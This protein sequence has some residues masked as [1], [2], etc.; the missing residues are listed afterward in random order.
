MTKA[1]IKYLL[2]ISILLLG[3]SNQLS[4]YNNGKHASFVPVQHLKEPKLLKQ[5][6]ALAAAFSSISSGQEKTFF[7]YDEENVEEE[8]DH[9]LVSNH[10]LASPFIAP[11][12]FYSWYAVLSVL[13]TSKVL[14]FSKHIQHFSLNKLFIVFSVFRI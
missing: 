3:L 14:H 13:T 8:D 11:K 1:T 6:Q 7:D 2:S 4:A 5:Q 10:Q 9:A 12:L